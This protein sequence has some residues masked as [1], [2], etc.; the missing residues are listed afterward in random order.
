M[1]G[2]A[3]NSRLERLRHI[4][5][6]LV[7][8]A[9]AGGMAAWEA[10]RI[11][12]ARTTAASGWAAGIPAGAGGG[13]VLAALAAVT[14]LAQ[15]RRRRLWSR[16]GGPQAIPILTIAVLLVVAFLTSTP[17]RQFRPNPAPYVITSGVEV[18][19][20]GYVGISV[21]GFAVVVIVAGLVAQARE[22]RRHAS[23][24]MGR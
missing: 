19:E 17:V 13:L 12:D 15:R 11:A 24:A 14:V 10:V 1:P 23:T 7:F 5:Q 18:A 22:R 21:A 4:G 16:R 3:K 8:F 2:H 9:A 20:I 6:W